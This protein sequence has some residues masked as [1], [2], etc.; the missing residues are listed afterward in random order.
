MQ[1]QQLSIVISLL[2][3]NKDGKISRLELRDDLFL[4]WYRIMRPRE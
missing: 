1:A 2:A 3:S 4:K